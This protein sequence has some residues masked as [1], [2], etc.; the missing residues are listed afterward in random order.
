MGESAAK[1]LIKLMLTGTRH[2]PS[3]SLMLTPIYATWAL[4]SGE[5]DPWV[6]LI[7]SPCCGSLILSLCPLRRPQGSPRSAAS[8]GRVHGVSRTSDAGNLESH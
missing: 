1:K 5:A 2:L 8:G 3:M 4:E 6:R 7:P